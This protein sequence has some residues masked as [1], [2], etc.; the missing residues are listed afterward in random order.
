M[1]GFFSWEL[2]ALGI[3]VKERLGI[4][5]HIFYQRVWK[6]S[7]LSQNCSEQK[8]SFNSTGQ[9]SDHFC[10]T[11]FCPQ[12]GCLGLLI[13]EKPRTTILICSWG[14]LVAVK[15]QNWWTTTRKSLCFIVNMAFQPYVTT[16]KS[17]SWEDGRKQNTSSGSLKK[18]LVTP[19]FLYFSHSQN[20]PHWWW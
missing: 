11:V 14:T 6:L 10:E 13:Y 18:I 12:G 4:C 8:Q 5:M 15:L 16:W 2:V 3:C 17:S 7:S 19:I 9:N 20:E 1:F